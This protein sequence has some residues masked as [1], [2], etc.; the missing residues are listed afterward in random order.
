MIQEDLS[1]GEGC[2]QEFWITLV[3]ISLSNI[4]ADRT[5]CTMCYAADATNNMGLG[6][7]TTTANNLLVGM[8]SIIKSCID[9]VEPN[10][11]QN[12]SPWV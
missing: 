5:A 8:Y 6:M 7:D 4:R 2:D 11:G 1:L 9:L 10:Q 3:I 12:T